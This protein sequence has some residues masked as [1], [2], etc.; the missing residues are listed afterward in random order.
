MSIATSKTYINSNATHNISWPINDDTIEEVLVARYLWGGG[1]LDRALIAKRIWETCVIPAIL[2]C[3]EA[4]LIKK[5]QL[6]NG[7]QVSASTSSSSIC[8]EC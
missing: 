8:L 1:G 3:I 6:L 2:Y 7:L 5:V 4:I